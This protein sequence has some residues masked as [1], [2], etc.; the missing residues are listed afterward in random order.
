MAPAAQISRGPRKLLFVARGLQLDAVHN[1]G[2]ERKSQ[3]SCGVGKRSIQE[4]S[5]H[6]LCRCEFQ[7][8]KRRPLIF[9]LFRG[10]ALRAVT[11]D[12]QASDDDVESAIS[13][14]LSL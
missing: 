11:A 5:S 13:L 12:F 9:R 1:A 8:G 14:N 7:A 3:T 6:R 4:G 2:R 10:A